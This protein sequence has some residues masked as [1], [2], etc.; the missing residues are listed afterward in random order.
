MNLENSQNY[1]GKVLAQSGDLR[2]DACCTFEMPA[3]DIRAALANVHEDVKARYYGCGLVTP[4]AL[5]GC[6]VL[7]LGS[8]SGQDV[9]L[10]AQLVGPNGSVTGVDATPEQLAVA[11]EHQGWHA[12]RFGY[13]NTNFVEGDIER[14]DELGLEPGS[15]DVIVSNCVI[16]LVADKAAVFRAAHR[17]LKPGG[18]LYFS[19]VYAD[20]R[21]PAHLLDDPVLHGE[22]LSGALYWGDFERLAKAAGFADPRLVTD[23][24][25]GI[26]DAEAAAKLQGISFVS[27]TYRLFRLDGLEPQCED[28]GQAVRYKGDL[29]GHEQ[30]FNLDAHHAIEAGRI[31]PVCGNSWLM[32]AESRLAD[33]FEFFG[34]FSRHYGVFP[35]CGTAVPF[36]QSDASPAKAEAPCC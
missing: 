18:E 33:H 19:D 6:N 32:L 28:Y 29:P 24:P 11:R 7:D 35:R 25:L 17:L 27:A 12:E 5:E 36:G 1:Y 34:D 14:L 16:N 9:Y 23:R 30:A 31:F 8:G 15:F 20:R 2:T 22:C 21:V 10:L 4:Q 13:A 3:P 26:N